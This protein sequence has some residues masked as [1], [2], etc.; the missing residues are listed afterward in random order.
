MP[1]QVSELDGG[2]DAE[3]VDAVEGAA[4]LAEG[5]FAPLLRAGDTIGAL[6]Q[7]HRD[8]AARFRQ[9]GPRRRR[10]MTSPLRGA[11]R[12]AVRLVSSDDGQ[13]RAA[14][15]G[16]ALCPMLSMGA[17][18]AIAPRVRRIEAI[19]PKSFPVNGGNHDLTEPQ[20]G[21]VSGALKTAP[22]GDGSWRIKGTHLHHLWRS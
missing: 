20:A 15:I 1:L 13:S 22:S 8:H 21:G 14:N 5:E 17:I 12:A 6:G 9:P 2:P 4:A 3:M 11:W 19:C 7:W 10:W 16:F 18:E